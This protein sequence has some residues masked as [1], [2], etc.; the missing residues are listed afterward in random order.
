M[1]RARLAVG[2]ALA[3]T[4]AWA[5]A[6]NAPESLLP[7]GFDE[8][9]SQPAP[10]PAAPAPAPV[11]RPTRSAAEPPAPVSGGQSAVSVASSADE[12]ARTPANAEAVKAL[13]SLS[14]EEIEKLT[15]EE[16][17]EAL[18]VKPKFDIPPAARRSMKRVGILDADEG[19]MKAGGFTKQN[20]SLVKAALDG[21]RGQLVSRW[22]HILLRRVLAS[23]LD[24]P[25]GMNPADFAAM[26]AALLYRMGEGD[27]ARALVQDVDTGNYTPRLVD[28]A[29]DAYVATADFTGM[30]P[31]VFLHGGMRK[32]PKWEVSREICRA[33]RGEGNAALA[34]LDRALSRETMPRIDLLL[35]QKYTGA[36]GKAR[37]AVNI[38]WDDVNDMTPWRYALT[39]AV[40][41][42]PPQGLMDGASARYD[43]MAATAPMLGLERRAA[44]ADR[45]GGAG[46]LSSRAMID[47][48]SQIYANSDV[49]GAWSDRA[50]RLQDAYLGADPQARLL[51]MQELWNGAAGIQQRYSRQ[52]LTAYAAARFPVDQQFADAAPLLIAS[53][54]TAGLDRNA[55]RWASVAE[56][57]STSWGLL[58]V[59]A[60]SRSAPVKAD[61]LDSFIGDDDSEEARKSAFLIAGLAGLGRISESTRDDMASKLDIDLGS[62]TRWTRMIDKAADVKNP[63][64]VALLAGLGMQ[65]EDWSKMTPRYLYHIVSALRRV[66]LEAEARMIAAEAVA[67]G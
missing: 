26:R 11:A 57:G 64:V 28:A 56:V 4:S 24:A 22:G 29:F 39:I 55:M 2:A 62:Q 33:F 51:A 12:A 8:P 46:I 25:K 27:A 23:R 20:A 6:Q 3:L 36:A 34:G 48:Y 31:A 47:L 59:A 13:E 63:A 21:N 30:C 49:T 35:A 38:E 58:V 52:V 32:D 37:R 53:M 14:L 18:G 65:G 66:G 19:G 44:A 60:P 40:G 16:L 5:L 45:A 15:P 50:E 43:Y 1:K 54:L 67:R 7:P 10:A 42:E 17:E 9:V 61:A 41:L